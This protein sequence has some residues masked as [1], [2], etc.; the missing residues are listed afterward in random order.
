MLFKAFFEYKSLAQISLDNVIIAY[1]NNKQT[2]ALRQAFE[3]SAC[4]HS[5]ATIKTCKRIYQ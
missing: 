3:E 4:F 1:V 2:L 5:S